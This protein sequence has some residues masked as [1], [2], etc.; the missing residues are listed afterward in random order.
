LAPVLNGKAQEN[1]ANN[2]APKEKTS[3]FSGEYYFPSRISG[4]MYY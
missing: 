4:A 2:T 1:I 3:A